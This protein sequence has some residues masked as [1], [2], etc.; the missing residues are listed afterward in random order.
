MDVSVYISAGKKGGVR[1]SD[2]VAILHTCT[3][4]Q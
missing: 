4:L 1:V 2:N 3:V